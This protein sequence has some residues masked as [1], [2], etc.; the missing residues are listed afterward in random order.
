MTGPRLPD[1]VIVGAMRSGTSSLFR[2]LA[3]HPDVFM[4]TPKEL[5]YFDKH[6]ERGRDWYRAR[7]SGATSRQRVGEATPSYL[8]NPV[9][10]ERLAGDVEG[11]K[12]IAILRDPVDRAYSHYWLRHARKREPRSWEEVVAEDLESTELGTLL[13]PSRYAIHLENL[14]AQVGRERSLILSFDRLTED[15]VDLFATVCS[16]VGVEP[17]PPESVG[18]IVNAHFEIRSQT[19][20]KLTKARRLP[21]FVRNAIARANHID[22]RYPP[23]SPELEERLS[24]FFEPDSRALRRAVAASLELTRQGNL[25]LAPPA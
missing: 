18:S 22:I 14:F 17:T 2:Y 8:Y 13:W 19:L 3:D 9:A 12:A 20:R 16:F 15:P 6:Y 1:F 7:F 24:A 23:M 5:H 25:E 10:L 21:R 11:V 4:A